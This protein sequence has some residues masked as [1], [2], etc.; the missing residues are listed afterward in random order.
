MVHRLKPYY[1][2]GNGK[3]SDPEFHRLSYILK[4]FHEQFGELFTDSDRVVRL[5]VENIAP[6]LAMDQPYQIAKKNTPNAGRIEL[7][8]ALMRV[9][10]SLLLK[11]D[12]EF[13]KQFV[14]N[15]PFKRFVTDIVLKL[16]AP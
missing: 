1:A 4:S 7:D 15:E 11:S 5:I 2:V 16:T 9:I 14:Q 13:Y 12:D 8:A 10:G 3:K 6:R